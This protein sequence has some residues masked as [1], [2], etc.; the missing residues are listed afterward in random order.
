MWEISGNF[1][2]FSWNLQKFLG[3]FFSAGYGW[4]SQEFMGFSSPPTKQVS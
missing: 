4:G 3:I 2:E 1:P